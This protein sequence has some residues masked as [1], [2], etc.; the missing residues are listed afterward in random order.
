VSSVKVGM[1]GPRGSEAASQ[2]VIDAL[3]DHLDR[4]QRH[5]RRAAGCAAP[6][7]RSLGLSRFLLTYSRFYSAADASEHDGPLRF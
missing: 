4:F 6:G 7:M 2:T 3:V 5:S 1:S